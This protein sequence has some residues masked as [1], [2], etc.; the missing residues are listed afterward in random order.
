[1]ISKLPLRKAPPSC[2]S[3]RPSLEN[4]NAMSLQNK[5]IAFIERELGGNL[6]V[7]R[8][9]PNTPALVGAG[10]AALAKGT[11]ATDDDLATAEAILRAV[12]VTVRVDE[13]RLDAVTA[14]S[15]S[16]PAYVFFLTE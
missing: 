8:V 6:R 5:T 16:G 11:F 13:K 14:L 2:A 7:V 1:M 3:A 9:M 12:G 15:G 4:E 10:A